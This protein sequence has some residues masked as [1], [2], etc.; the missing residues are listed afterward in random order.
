MAKL[1]VRE[2]YK[3][4][5]K[6]FNKLYANGAE[7]GMMKASNHLMQEAN[8]TIP[9]DT[10]RMVQSGR[11]GRVPGTKG[12]NTQTYVSYSTPYVIWVHED[13]NARHG[14]IFNAHYAADIA[15]G[16]THQRRPQESAKFLSNAAFDVTVQTRLIEIV[17]DAIL[18]ELAKM[19]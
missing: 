11:V 14:A 12:I 10:G 13:L 4:G 16:K 1:W 9:I 7:I 18:A 19:P 5:L 6:A 8:H 3:E 15:S 2:T 17:R